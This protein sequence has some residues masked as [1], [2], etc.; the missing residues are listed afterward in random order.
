MA[1]TPDS[2]RVTT[3]N[4][5]EYQ[6]AKAALRRAENAWRRSRNACLGL[7]RVRRL[8]DPAGAPSDAEQ[9]AEQAYTAAANALG[10]ARETLR[11]LNL[12]RPKAP[13]RR[14]R[15]CGDDSEDE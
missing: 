9:R 13:A 12:S 2:N 8:T 1:E 3:A 4:S 14:Q 5:P 6:Q 10:T 11:L 15:R 7:R